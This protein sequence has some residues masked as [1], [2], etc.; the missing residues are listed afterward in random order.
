MIVGLNALLAVSLFMLV[1]AMFSGALQRTWLTAPMLFVAFGWLIGPDVLE[2]F[3][4]HADSM[5]LYVVAE[6]TLILVLFTDATRI[7][8]RAL[9]RSFSLPL[10]MLMFG[11]PLT[12]GLG[13]LVGVGLFPDFNLLQVA[14]LAAILAPTD[15]ALGQVVVSSPRVPTRIGRL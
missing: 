1:F 14:V 10:R 13:T 6:I 11:L 4:L 5:A 8:L 2:I 3:Q 9:R 15:A 12:M 7:P